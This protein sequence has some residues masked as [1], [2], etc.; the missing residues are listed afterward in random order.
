MGPRFG[1]PLPL[2][3]RFTAKHRSVEDLKPRTPGALSPAGRGQWGIATFTVV[4]GQSSPSGHRSHARLA[5]NFTRSKSNLRHTRLK[6]SALWRVAVKRLCGG[7][8]GRNPGSESCSGS[9]P[10]Q[11][12]RCS[13]GHFFGLLFSYS[14]HPALR[15]SGRLRRSH[16]LMR[17]RGPAKKSD[18]S[19][20]RGSKRPLRRRHPGDNATTRRAVTGFLLWQG[21][22]PT[23][24]PA[25][26]TKH[27]TSPH[28]NRR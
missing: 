3:S 27:P 20:G 21:Q 9:Y 18:S 6:P 12:Y 24:A 16:A 28:P 22:R 5:V 15:P 26:P 19:L 7:E 11:R 10:T 4:R 14:G 17:V 13:K 8:D 23:R 25:A 1:T 2:H